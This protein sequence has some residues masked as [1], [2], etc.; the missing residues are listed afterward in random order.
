[1]NSDKM[2]SRFRL[3]IADLNAIEIDLDTSSLSEIELIEQYQALP[4]F[5][6]GGQMFFAISDL[7]VLSV[8]NQSFNKAINAIIVDR[9]VMNS[10]H[11][12]KWYS[13]EN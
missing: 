5:K 3:P 6:W 10:K 12:I 4:L 11:A 7:L 13:D 9:E 2:A 8:L 1:M